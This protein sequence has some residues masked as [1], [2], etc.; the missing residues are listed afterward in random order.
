MRTSRF[1]YTSIALSIWVLCPSSVSALDLL[2]SYDAALLEDADYQAARAAAD[3]GRELVPMARAQLLPNISASASRMK[4]D[5]TSESQTA[6]GRTVTSESQ[7]KSKSDSLTLRQPLYRPAQYAGYLQ[8]EARV[9]GVEASFERAGK[10][11]VLRLI[12]AY[13]NVLLAGNTLLQ[14]EAQE[15]AIKAQLASA[16]RAFEVGQGTRTDIDDA[17]AKLDLNI[18]RKLGTRQSIE[19]SRHELAVLINRTVDQVKPLNNERLAQASLNPANLDEWMSQAGELSPEL[20]ELQAQLEAAH[21]EVDRAWAGHKPTLDLVIQQSMSSSDNITNPNSRYDNK[22]IGVQLTVPLFAGGYVIAQVSQAQAAAVE[23]EKKLEA[24][25]RKLAAQVRKEFNG[26]QEGILKIKALE[27]AERSAIQSV[28][29]NEKGFKAGTRTRVDILNAEEQLS[30][31]RL[32]LGR[33]R[34]RYVLSHAR[35]LGLSGRLGRDEVIGLN[36]W[37]GE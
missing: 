27:Q 8:A 24:G 28:R 10:D 17:Q 14:T 30:N 15:L 23:A 35:L 4:N 1:L 2:E 19:Q 33:E 13:M 6:L 16:T 20:R 37:L 36:L 25:R 3:A 9:T 26:V 32:E 22:Q 11:L 31:T 21:H 18:S 12:E 34:V 29:S 5:L 7:Y